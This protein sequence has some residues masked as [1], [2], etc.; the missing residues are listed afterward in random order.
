MIA[1]QCE[2][3]GGVFDARRDEPVV[4]GDPMFGGPNQC[5]RWNTCPPGVY[6]CLICVEAELAG[7]FSAYVPSLPGVVSEGDTEAEA[8]KHMTEALLGALRSYRDDKLPIP[9]R[10]EETAV[11]GDVFSK[12]IVVHA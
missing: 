12:W 7:G 6:R 8:I 10:Q 2:A 1:T 11:T 3:N 5:V 9:W 4:S